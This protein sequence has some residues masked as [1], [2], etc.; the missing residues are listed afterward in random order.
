MTAKAQAIKGKNRNFIKNKN[1]C[2]SKETIKKMRR[3]LRAWGESICHS[4]C[5]QEPVKTGS[6]TRTFDPLN[7]RVTAIHPSFSC[8][9]LW[10]FLFHFFSPLFLF[11]ICFSF[12]SYLCLGNVIYIFIFIS[13]ILIFIFAFLKKNVT[14]EFVW[15]KEPGYH[16]V[17]LYHRS[18]ASVYLPQAYKQTHTK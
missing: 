6:G 15:V 10:S 17:L 1:V 7:G 9:C 4:L 8:F 14:R 16:R 18:P 11:S 12:V 13:G 3:R 5:L 2:V